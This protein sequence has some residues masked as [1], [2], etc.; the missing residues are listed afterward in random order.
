MALSVDSTMVG[1]VID[2]SPGSIVSVSVV[3]PSGA[4]TKRPLCL[5]DGTVLAARYPSVG[6]PSLYCVGTE[7]AQG[8]PFG[9]ITIAYASLMVTDVPPGASYS[10]STT[11]SA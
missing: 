4:P 1:A 2:A 9:P 3:T 10:V 7:S 8:L 5:V 11:N 6:A